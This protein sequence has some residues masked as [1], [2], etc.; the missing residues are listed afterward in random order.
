[1]HRRIGFVLAS[2]VSVGLMAGCGG[3]G[4]GSGTTTPK[5]T[6]VKFSIA[7]AA[8]S[9]DIAAP[10]SALSAV[11]TLQGGSSA[12]GDFTTEVDRAAAPAAYSQT[13]T[14]AQT[15][16]TGT[17][18]LAI[19]FY[20]QAGGTGAIVGTASASVTIAANGTGI[21]SVSVANKV[22]TAVV[23][24][25]QTVS[26]PQ[27]TFLT[28]TARD[29]QGNLIAVTPG[30]GI[31]SQAD[32][33]D[34]LQLTTDGKATALK[35]GLSTISVSVDGIPSA[36]AAVEVTDDP[37]GTPV[38]LNFDELAAMPTQLSGTLIPVANQLSTQYQAAHGISFS[39][40]APFVAVTKMPTGTA[41]SPPNCICGSSA[42]GHIQYGHAT[43]VNFVFSDPLNPATPGVTRSFSLAGDK[44]GLASNTVEIDAYDVAGNLIG[45]KTSADSGGEV[46]SISFPTAQIHK[47][48]FLG[49][50]GTN[51]GVALD[52]VTFGP[53][54]P[55]H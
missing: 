4:G 29:G 21:G 36:P 45:T 31:W 35:R 49:A 18:P 1:M 24:A 23:T 55:A 53:V 13:Y 47:V 52:N 22:A 33:A 38:V 51:D 34:N 28:F 11:V 19:T 15:A 6:T 41:P 30:S 50:P 20:A 27:L 16:K 39:S 9:R 48:V 10:S 54:V 12:G 3:S 26:V 44:D 8:R 37:N 25:G 14:S 2:V 7:W 40:L 5:T 43:P 42:D 17:Y 32:G 46:L